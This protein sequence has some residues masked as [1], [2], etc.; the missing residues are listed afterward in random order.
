MKESNGKYRGESR[1]E[2]IDD[3]SPGQFATADFSLYPAS[4]YE[5]RNINPVVRC[6]DDELRKDKAGEKQI[7]IV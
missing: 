4:V 3:G 6:H 7:H 1:K 2:G 5:T